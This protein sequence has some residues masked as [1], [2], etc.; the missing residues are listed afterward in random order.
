MK[1][2]IFYY[3]TARPSSTTTSSNGSTQEHCYNSSGFRQS[4]KMDCTTY[5]KMAG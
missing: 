3:F 5:W 1:I 4:E 2:L